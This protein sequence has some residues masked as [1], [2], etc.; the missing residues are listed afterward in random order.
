LGGNYLLNVGPTAAGEILPVHADRLRR[1]GH[2][3]DRH[4]ESI[5]STRAGVVYG[6]GVVSTRR[7][8]T[9]FVHVLEYNSDYARLTGVPMGVNSAALLDGSSVKMFT[10]DEETVLVIPAELRDPYCTVV[11]LRS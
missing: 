3:L 5:Y 6:P 2:W 1:V 9:H 7:D 4:G 10:K 8:N 11:R